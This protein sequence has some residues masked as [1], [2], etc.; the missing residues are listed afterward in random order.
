M[1]RAFRFMS[2]WQQAVASAPGKQRLDGANPVRACARIHSLLWG[3]LDVPA[4]TFLR[5]AKSWEARR[6]IKK[7]SIGPCSSRLRKRNSFTCMQKRHILEDAEHIQSRIFAAK[8]RVR[9][10][11]FAVSFL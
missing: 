9:Y 10:S 2:S 6:V 7:I 4:V 1:H 11:V 8:E 5:E 3:A